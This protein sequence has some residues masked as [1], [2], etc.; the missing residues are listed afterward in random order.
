L[1]SLGPDQKKLEN[2]LEM[3]GT[4][5]RYLVFGYPPFIKAFVDSSRLDLSKYNMDLIVG[6]EGISEGLRTYLLKYFKTVISSYGASDLEI[7]IGV[8]TDLTINLRRRCM[9]DHALCEKLFGRNSPPMIFQYSALDYIIETA[10]TGELL[11]TIGRQASA[12]PKIRYNLRDIGGVLSYKQLS[13][14][15]AAHGVNISALTNRQSKFPILFVF[16]RGDLT[17]P[18]YGSKIFPSNLEE[19]ISRNPALVASVNSF[20]IVSFENE[21]IDRQLKIHLEMVQSAVELPY[22]LEVLRDLFFDGLCEL[23]QDFREVTKMFD[24]SCI[25]IELHPYG[26][27][28]FK[29]RDIRIKSKYIG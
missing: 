11:F 14:M 5:Y 18:F 2:T 10:E 16:G 25:S 28:P 9:E 15:L 13:G 26:S 1:K 3:F 22:S 27:G 4:E 17:V 19:I 24:R 23:N 8:E 12:A 29:D 20:Q 7:N 6:G 21:Q